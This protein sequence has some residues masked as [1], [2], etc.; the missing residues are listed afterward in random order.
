MKKIYFAMVALCVAATAFSQGTITGTVTDAELGEPLPGANVVVQGTTNGTTTDFDGNFVIEVSKNTGTLLVSYIGFVT[1]KV[2]YTTVGAIGTITLAPDAEELEG[3]V[4]TGIMDIAKDRETPVAVS[5]IRATEIREKLGSQE[6]PEI[7]K[8][9]PSVYATKSGGGFGDGRVNVRGFES[10][11]IAIMVN[12][13]PVND[14]ENGFVYWSNW[15]GLSDVTTGMQVQRG[16]GSSK[17]AISSVGGTINIITKTTEQSQGGAV[18]VGMGNDGYLKTNVAYNTGKS[19]SGFAAS[20]LL[21]RTAGDGY[22]DGT[23]FEGY[24][25]FIG[26]GYEPNEKHSF[27]FILT[28]APQVHD[29]RT[30]SFF[31]VATV[32]DYLEYGDKYNYNHGFLNGEEFGWRSN[33]YHKPITS[34][35]WEWKM[36]EK[37]TLAT[38]AYASFGRGGGTGDIGS[39]PGFGFASSSRYRNPENGQVD[40]DL[41]SRFNGGEAVTFYDG[42]DYQL[43]PNSDG[44][45]LTTDFGDGLTR[46]ASMNSHN[47]FGLI[48]NLHTDINEKF[49]YDLG[50]DLRSYKGIHY[51]RVDNLL[52]ADGYLDTNDVNDPEHIVRQNATVASDFSSILNVFKDID[53]EEKIDYYN[54]GLVRWYGAF[55]QMEYKTEVVSAF[56]Q[57]G[58]SQ[59]GFKR[60]DYFN[61]LDSDPEQ[62]TDWENILGGNIKGGLNV[63]INEENNV[64]VN[65]GYYS[66]Q[67]NFDAIF[68]NFVNDLNPDYRNEKIFGLE[69]GYGLNLGDFRAKLNVYRT[70]WKDRFINVEVET[71]T[72]DEGFANIS[73]VEQVHKGVEIEADY[74]ASEVV[75]F[76]GMISLGDWEY[77]GNV[78]GVA[79]DDSQNVIDDDVN[80]YLDGVKV[81][82]AAQF[83]S[84]L[85]MVIRPVES[86]KLSANWF[87]AAKLYA[88]ILAE[89]FDEPNH[90]GSLRLPTYNLFDAGAYY[91]FKFGGENAI[92]LALN[93]N[94]VFNTEYLAESLT[95]TFPGSGDTTYEGI[96]TSNKAFFGFGRT[97]N[98]SLRYSF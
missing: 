94:N 48:A 84:N 17:L 62:E 81:G 37:S 67:P 92:G 78:S 8:S 3:V 49:S 16:L 20:V 89:D 42:R 14:M 47:W 88:D 22:I 1:K 35:T 63:N 91:T 39:G 13:I 75:Q 59:Q 83:T 93:V 54:D 11:N 58:I 25:Y 77:A 5:T 90:Q 28:G 82:N 43:S 4:V 64:F 74:R 85:E 46:R 51:R 66:K 44:E 76:K 38:S 18:T 12:G 15:A 50:V 33:F 95:N 6:F 26:L 87:T 72:G 34:L 80:L 68:L 40:Y 24:N 65:G 32:E 52:G 19:D 60:I 9:T 73:G 23:Q 2:N 7:L 97:W 31:N 41:I 79:F 70:S 55:G 61:Y 53:K 71:T 27:Q 98:L 57:G 56:V 69:A 96:A 21:G 86:L 29:Q 10:P 30:T 45:Y 36:S